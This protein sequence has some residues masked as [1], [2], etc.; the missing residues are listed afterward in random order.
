MHE[1]CAEELM[2]AGD[3]AGFAYA[4]EAIQQS[5]QEKATL[6]S[7]LHDHYAQTRTAD[8]AALLEFLNKPPAP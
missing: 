7:F 2:N 6:I 4:R 1:A 5:K 8:P 3:A